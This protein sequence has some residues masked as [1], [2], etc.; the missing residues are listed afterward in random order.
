M[1]RIDAIKKTMRKNDACKT[2][3]DYLSHNK[4]LTPKQLWDK[5]QVYEYLMWIIIE[6]FGYNFYCRIDD[7][8]YNKAIKKFPSQRNMSPDD[9]H[10]LF[11]KREK[12]KAKLLKEKI[13]YTRI[14]SKLFK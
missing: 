13:S 9:I 4:H 6:A 8:L 5:C 2:S 3:F 1:K 12:Y 10:K 7:S 11:N 14:A